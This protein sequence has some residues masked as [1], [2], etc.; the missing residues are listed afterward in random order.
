M[1]PPSTDVDD[2]CGSGGGAGACDGAGPGA[3]AACIDDDE[4]EDEFGKT[5][6]NELVNTDVATGFG[7]IVTSGLNATGSALIWPIGPSELLVCT[8]CC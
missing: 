2:V 1:E 4:D 3:S 8:I 7:F 6:F 5:E